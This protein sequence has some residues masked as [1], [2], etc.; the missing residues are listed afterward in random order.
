MILFGNP[1]VRL[2]NFQL[3]PDRAAKYAGQAV[4]IWSGEH[5]AYWR[6]NRSGYTTSRLMA[7]T[8]A[9]QDALAYSRH[10]GPEKRIAFEFVVEGDASGVTARPL[11]EWHEDYGS[12]TWWAYPVRE[13]PWIGT[14][15]DDTWPGY[16]THWSPLPPIPRKPPRKAAA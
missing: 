2:R 10:C 5:G 4:R 15:L 16:H 6:A 9:F 3:H 1:A 13:A 7:G 8:Y 11:S 12:V 14:P